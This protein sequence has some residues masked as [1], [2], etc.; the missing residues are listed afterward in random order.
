MVLQRSLE[1]PLSA[2]DTADVI[3]RNGSARGI[4]GLIESLKRHL[5]GL[6][7]LVDSSLDDVHTADIAK[8]TRLPER[9]ADLPAG[10]V[11]GFLET[12]ERIGQSSPLFVQAP[13]IA[14]KRHLENLA[15]VVPGDRQTCFKRIHGFLEI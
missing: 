12:R 2:V 9:I 4:A 11:V 6:H 7:C 1:V 14:E 8:R 10:P 13:D 5:P 3:E 15:H